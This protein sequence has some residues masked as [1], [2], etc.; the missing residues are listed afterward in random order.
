MVHRVLVIFHLVPVAIVKVGVKQQAA[1]GR[2]Y[3]HVVGVDARAAGVYIAAY[4]L[5]RETATL[6]SPEAYYAH[7]HIV[8]L[9]MHVFESRA[10][11]VELHVGYLHTVLIDYLALVG[12]VHAVMY[13]VQCQ[14]THV[15]GEDIAL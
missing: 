10:H 1:L 13:M 15:D 2:L 5:D 4:V 11:V 3:L 14:R 8:V 9:H 12:Q 7:L 6:F